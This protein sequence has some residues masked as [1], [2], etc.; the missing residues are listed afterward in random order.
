[1]PPYITGIFFGLIFIFSLGP[2]FFALVQTSVQKG[3][4]KALFLAFGISMSDIIYVVLALMGVVSF[5]ERPVFR[6]WMAIVGT[7]VLFAYGVYSWFKKP[8]VYEN[9]IAGGNEMSIIKYVAKGFI[10]NGLNPFIVIFWVGIIGV[11]AVKY[12]Y[13]FNQQVFFFMG[14]LTTILITDILKAL[15]AHRF[16]SVITPRSILILNRSIGVILIIFGLQMV[17]FLFN[18]F[19]VID[20]GN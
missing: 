7:L 9:E 19:W 14:A 4:K 18:N 16:R 3:F 12:D 6:M 2:G 13:T 15:I 17:Y 1:M 8:K 5:L 10:L 11:V 20:I